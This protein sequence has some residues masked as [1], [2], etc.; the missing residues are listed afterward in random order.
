MNFEIRAAELKLGSSC[1]VALRSLPQ[2]FGIESAIQVYIKKIEILPTY[3]AVAE[4]RVVGF[5]SIEKHFAESAEIHVMGI[6]PEF[7]RMGIGIALLN[8]AEL[9]L[10]AQ[11]VRFLQVKTLSPSNP[12]KNYATTRRFYLSM[13]FLPLEEMPEL[14]G[15]ENPCLIMIKSLELH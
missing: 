6:L 3:T 7:H 4:N 9:D 8:K 2:W 12:D 5:L 10:V 11:G 14:W 15:V 13:G 1:E